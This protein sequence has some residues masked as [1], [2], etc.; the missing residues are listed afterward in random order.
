M[1]DLVEERRKK[2]SHSLKKKNLKLIR[3]NMC[4]FGGE[5]SK[6]KAS[7]DDFK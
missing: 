7:C 4:L 1:L 5:F 6:V 2:T 3:K